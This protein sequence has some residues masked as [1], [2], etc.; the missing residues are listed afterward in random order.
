MKKKLKNKKKKVWNNIK[1]K[2]YEV[3]NDRLYLFN[4]FPNLSNNNIDSI[5]LF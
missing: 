3:K 2:E 4:L 5:E 1:M